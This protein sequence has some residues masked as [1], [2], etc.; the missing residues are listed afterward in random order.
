MSYVH[1]Q[2]E[3]RPAVFLGYRAG[4]II[5]LVAGLEHGA[6]P[7][8]ST[9][10]PVA[11]ALLL[12]VRNPLG[13]IALAIF[14]LVYAL[15]CLQHE[16]TAAIDVDEASARLVGVG[17]GNGSFKSIMVVCVIVRC[18]EWAIQP[19][20]VGQLDHEKL[21]VGL[22]TATGWLPACNELVDLCVSCHLEVD[23]SKQEIVLLKKV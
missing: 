11:G 18:R 23:F 8:G 10:H 4:I 2:E 21:V 5:S 22:L 12:A 20:H 1:D 17:K 6:V 9:P 13:Q 14:L 3:G 19:K 16:M 7:A 15:L